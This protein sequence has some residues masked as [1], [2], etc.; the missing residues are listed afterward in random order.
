MNAYAAMLEDLRLRR[1]CHAQH[2]KYA[3][4]SEQHM[5]ESRDDQSDPARRVRARSPR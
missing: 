1:E 3:D 4:C 5:Q 2:G